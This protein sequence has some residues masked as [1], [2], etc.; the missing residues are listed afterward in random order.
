MEFVVGGDI[1]KKGHVGGTVAQGGEGGILGQRAHL[2]SRPRHPLAP[3]PL[4][5]ARGHPGHEGDDE[6]SAHPLEA[7]L[8]A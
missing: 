5:L 4:P 7:T 1:A 3:D 8:G 2:E 6:G